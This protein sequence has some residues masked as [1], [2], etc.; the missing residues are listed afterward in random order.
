MDALEFEKMLK[1]HEKDIFSFCLYLAQDSHKA[2]DLYQESLLTAFEKRDK[3]IPDNNPKALIF[4]IAIGKWR[5]IRRKESRRQIIAPGLSL[6]DNVAVL[7]APAEIN[8]ESQA[9]S[10]YEKSVIRENLATMDD[11]FRIPLILLYFDDWDLK[12][13]A[14]ALKLPVGTVKSRL[15]KGRSLIKKALEQE[16]GK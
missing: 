16:G 1:T 5:N 4:S 7:A 9:L 8:P 12:S 14:Q 3:I 6:E 2:A 15:H 13:I 10:Q 11:K